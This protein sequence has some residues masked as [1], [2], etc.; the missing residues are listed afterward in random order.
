[1]MR[2]CLVPVH[3]QWSDI[4]KNII[5]QQVVDLPRL[6]GNNFAVQPIQ[7][8][9]FIF[10]INILKC[11]CHA[12]VY[13]I[14]IFPPLSSFVLLHSLAMN[15]STWGYMIYPLPTALCTVYKGEWRYHS[16]FRAIMK[17]YTTEG[18]HCAQNFVAYQFY[19]PNEND[20]HA[21]DSVLLKIIK[22]CH[23]WWYGGQSESLHIVCRWCRIFSIRPLH[24]TYG[25]CF[26]M[27]ISKMDGRWKERNV[28][29]IMNMN[30]CAVSW[31]QIKM[32]SFEKKI[33]HAFSRGWLYTLPTFFFSYDS[34]MQI[35]VGLVYATWTY[36]N[37]FS[38]N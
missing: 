12:T 27:I 30:L 16:Y 9:K 3:M 10:G 24:I 36:E 33:S 14:I 31:T 20:I 26:P 4:V 19:M 28:L 13:N 8:E 34:C 23:T 21:F 17:K 32:E 37:K 7:E 25:S 2:W 5:N 11:F 6:S 18:H 29:K 38:P 15:M 22:Y 1:M 35:D